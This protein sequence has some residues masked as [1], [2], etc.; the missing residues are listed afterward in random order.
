MG[1]C[2]VKGGMIPGFF[3]IQHLRKKVI[4]NE[5]ATNFDERF[6]LRNREEKNLFS[7]NNSVSDN[8]EYT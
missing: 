3:I 4:D 2:K 6:C 7:K 1:P 8:K 5:E